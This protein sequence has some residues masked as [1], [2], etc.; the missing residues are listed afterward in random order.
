M[1]VLLSNVGR[2]GYL[3]K[4]FKQ[5]LG[6]AGEVW[7]SDSSPYTPAFRYCDNALLASKVETTGYVDKLLSRCI[8]NKIDMVV[9]LIDPTLEILAPHRDKFHKKGVTV[10]VSPAKTIEITFDKYKTYLHAKKAGIAVPETVTTIE[11]A[12]KLIASMENYPGPL[13]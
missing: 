8:K 5:T 4:Y 11:E 6:D 10:V 3:V 2:R 9:P 12:L 13:W 7:G 1:R